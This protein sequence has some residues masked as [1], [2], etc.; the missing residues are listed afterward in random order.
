[1]K[2][3]WSSPENLILSNPRMPKSDSASFRKALDSAIQ[4]HSFASHVFILTSGTTASSA[5]GFKWVALP[6]AAVLAAAASSNRHLESG[7]NDVWLHCLPNFHIGG[8]S[9]WARAELCGAKVVQTNWDLEA[10]SRELEESKATLCSLVPTQVHDLV[11]RGVHA[12]RS[13]RALLLGGGAASQDLISRA[14]A[15][16]WPVLP[17]YG[18]SECSSQVATALLN[19]DSSLHVLSHLEV[20]CGENQRLKI[21]GESL[22]SGYILSNGVFRDP[23]EDGWFLTEDFGAV[24]DRVLTVLGRISERIKIGGET[25]HLGRLEGILEEEASR[26]DAASQ[27]VLLATA[28]ERLEAVIQVVHEE[29]CHPERV[30]AIVARYN[31]RVLPFEKIRAVHRVPAIPRTELGKIKRAELSALVSSRGSRP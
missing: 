29:R 7:T 15:L 11:S 20:C 31:Q 9:I 28:D 8:L 18:M 4:H 6:K 13:L 16:G 1:M 22:F 23:K 10:F 5:A 12:P 14:Y 19:G 30:Q 3:D 24:H 21:R 26:N 17:T 27:L 25:V 2:I